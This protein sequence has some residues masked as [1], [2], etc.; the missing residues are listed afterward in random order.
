EQNHTEGGSDALV[1]LP[2]HTIA[3]ERVK[4]RLTSRQIPHVILTGRNGIGRKSLLQQIVRDHRH[5]GTKFYWMD[6]SNIGPEDSRACLES[7]ATALGHLDEN[8]VLC[9]K[10]LACLL[11]RPQGGSNKPLL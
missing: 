3:L 6:C 10:G 2:S 5:I 9:L 11:K 4:R 1:E 7:L 8:V